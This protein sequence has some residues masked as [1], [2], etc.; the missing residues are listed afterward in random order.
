[1]DFTREIK[2]I[3]LMARGFGELIRPAEESNKLC[4]PW[5][6]VPKDR[7]YLAVRVC[8][9]LELCEKFGNSQARPLE[10]VQ[11]LYWHQGG[12]PFEPCNPSKCTSACDRVQVLLP[13]LNLGTCRDLIPF[14]WNLKGGVIFGRSRRITKWWPKNPKLE[15]MDEAACL[16]EDL[17][18]TSS[19]APQLKIFKD[20]GL[21]TEETLFNVS[22]MSRSGKSSRSPAV[23]LSLTADLQRTPTPSPRNEVLAPEV[24]QNLTSSTT[25]AEHPGYEI[26][27]PQIRKASRGL[28][29]V[30]ERQGLKNRE[31]DTTAG[32][33]AAPS[34]LDSHLAHRHVSGSIRN[35]MIGGVNVHREPLA[36]RNTRIQFKSLKK[37]IDY[38]F[39]KR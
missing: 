2:A 25:E 6:N 31:H 18:T 5:K 39:E 17:K 35:A 13:R 38:F 27:V 4:A 34:S 19:T 10:L 29:A 37:I 23:D 26:P 28:P 33:I 14:E 1:V 24:S 9:L 12:H 21:G 20:S 11:G 16:A 3:N 30:E 15:P 36:T 32:K 22:G 7:D 8:Y